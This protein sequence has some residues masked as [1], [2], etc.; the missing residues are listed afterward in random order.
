M[1]RRAVGTG[2]TP[3]SRRVRTR[4]GG[5]A[6]AKLVVGD[7]ASWIWNVA[8]DRWPGAVEVLDFYHASQH[9]V[10]SGRGGDGRTSGRALVGG[11]ATASNPPRR[12]VKNHCAVAARGWPIGSGPV[13]SACLQRQGRFK[14]SGQAWT[15]LGLRHLCPCSKRGRTVTGITSGITNRGNLPDAHLCSG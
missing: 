14:R 2:A 3:P 1:A 7:G 10:G 13:E 12:R 4:P 8:Q 11:E 9:V 5:R 6:Q 15:R